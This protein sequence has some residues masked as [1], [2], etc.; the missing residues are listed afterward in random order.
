MPAKK[1]K[2]DV[3]I[4]YS[5]KDE[6]WVVGTLLP[7][8]E[9]EGLVVCIDSRDFKPGVPS[10]VN[11]ENAAEE[12]R[13]TVLVLTPNWT[14]SEWTDFET[15]LVQ[16]D[17]PAG[18]R[19]KMI[20]LM[21]EQCNLPKRVKPLTYIDFTRLDRQDIAWWQLFNSLGV[22]LPGHAPSLTPTSNPIL[23]FPQNQRLPIKDTHKSPQF[24]QTLGN[25]FR[26]LPLLVK[27]LIGL[28][29]LAAVIVPL[30]LSGI[31]D[32]QPTPILSKTPEP[33]LTSNAMETLAQ[34]ATLVHSGAVHGTI[35]VAMAALSLLQKL[36]NLKKCKVFLCVLRENSL[37]T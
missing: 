9:K 30:T 11:M 13:H 6:N 3:F 32:S 23:V 1:Y 36:Q 29:I 15:I 14:N 12:S 33:T 28:A 22:D 21:L 20:P 18:R 37:R 8:L 26:Q 7:R 34:M 10:I 24:W 4:S 25:W 16:T 27:G 31:G 19:Q 17:D 2:Y 5:H 35:M